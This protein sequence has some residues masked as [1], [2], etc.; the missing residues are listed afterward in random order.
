MLTTFAAIEFRKFST[1]FTV[2]NA[3]FCDIQLWI[4]IDRRREIMVFYSSLVEKENRE[5][6][7]G[8]TDVVRG[9]FEVFWC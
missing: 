1:Y 2:N 7:I 9:R 4:S 3:L 6:V 5:A 8:M